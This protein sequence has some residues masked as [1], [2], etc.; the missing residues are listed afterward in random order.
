MIIDIEEIEAMC[1]LARETATE[2][3]NLLE[4]NQ[5]TTFDISKKGRINLVTEMDL[6][7]ERLIVDSIL[8][9]FPG[10]QILAEEKGVLGGNEPIRWIIDPLDGTTNYAHGYRFYCVS[11]G[12]EVEGTIVAGAVYDPV[13][14]ECFWAVQNQGA[15]LNERRVHVSSED[16]LIDSLVSTGFSYNESQ[17]TANL[18]HFKRII[19][20]TRA[21]RRDGAAALDLCYVACGRFDGFWELTLHPWDVA[22]G[23]LIIQEAGGMI[24][25]LDGSPCSVEDQEFLATNGKIHRALSQLLS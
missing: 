20:K 24:T 18:E 9:R 22:A 1:L 13:I 12:I 14:R 10:H 2:A 6:R 15:Y 5:A 7:S 4:A 23:L 8:D 17:V 25:R 21:V 16:E 3:G 11:I 19:Y